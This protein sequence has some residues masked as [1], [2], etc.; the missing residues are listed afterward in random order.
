M[1][2]G[3]LVVVVTGAAADVGRA[4]AL[5]FAADGARV[6]AV[7]ADRAGLAEVAY[8][9][10]SRVL[11]IAADVRQDGDVENVV[12]IARDRFQRIDVLI[13][14]PA[15][16]NY[17]D[18]LARPLPD[19]SRVIEVN[20]VGA[21]RCVRAVLP[22]MLES[23]HGRVLL[24]ASEEAESGTRGA[25][26]YAAASA[27]LVALARTLGKE[28]DRDYSPDVLINALLIG[29]TARGERADHALPETV[30]PEVRRLVTL[31]AAGPTGRLFRL[32]EGER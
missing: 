31:P 1:Q 24:L 26:A 25:S 23:G 10:G 13:T 3:S 30:Y 16:V 6:I 29:A 28:A 18:L 2:I 20:L 5:G 21:A 32:G 19:W 15:L 7:D 22:G 17:G 11:A 8:A 27:G 12:T 9:S 4:L 14:T